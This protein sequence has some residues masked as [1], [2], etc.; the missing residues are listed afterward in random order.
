MLFCELL[1]CDLQMYHG[2][3][4][5]GMLIYLL[6][7]KKYTTNIAISHIALCFIIALRFG[8][9]FRFYS[10]ELKVVSA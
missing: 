6:L 2:K 8:K 9:Q 1:N 3:C 10:D 7:K 5:Y 4:L